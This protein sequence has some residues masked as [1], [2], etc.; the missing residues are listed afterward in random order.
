MKRKKVEARN[1]NTHIRN[2]YFFRL[3]K[4]LVSRLMQRDLKISLPFKDQ[5][6]NMEQTQITRNSDELSS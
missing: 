2:K 5:L 3:A 6:L 4:L 1:K